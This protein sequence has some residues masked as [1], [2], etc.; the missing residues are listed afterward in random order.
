VKAHLIS[1][2]RTLRVEVGAE[3]SWLFVVVETDSGWVGVGE[4]SQSRLDEGVAAQVRALAPI[5]LGYDPRDIIERRSKPLRRADAH[6]IFFAATSAI[7]HALWDLAGQLHGAPVYDLLG[8]SVR[9]HVPL[10]ANLSL[11]CRDGSPESY[12]AA[13]RDAVRAGFTAVKI[14][15]FDSLPDLSLDDGSRGIALDRV[16]AVRRV[17]ATRAAVGRSVLLLVDCLSRLSLPDAYAFAGQI[18]GFDPY[19]LEDPLETLDLAAFAELRRAIPMRLAGGEQLSGRDA[20]QRLL[21]SGAVDVAM[22]DVKWV[23]GIRETQI[24]ATMAAADGIEV[25]PH[26]MSGPI[27]TAASLHVA[28]TAPNCTMVEYCW[29][30]PG[31]RN[32]LVGG[33]ED[34]KQGTLPRP[35]RPGLGLTLDLNYD[36]LQEL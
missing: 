31:W 7:E 21:R 2:L 11:A 32:D 26:N 18:A 22:P 14:D 27:A 3:R 29:G 16:D 34:V 5:Y 6:R 28:L 36:R 1:R 17:A 8:G 30:V 24:I 19:W 25:A 4:G 15:A 35:T 10:Y 13:A 23:G 12:A 20:F 9:D 33:A